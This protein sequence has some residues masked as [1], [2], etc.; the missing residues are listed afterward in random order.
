MKSVGI[1]SIA[2]LDAFV[3]PSQHL[4]WGT[5][6]LPGPG[7][8]GLIQQSVNFDLLEGAGEI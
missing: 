4:G 6:V 7:P 5:R 2:A 3:N 1:R 8:K